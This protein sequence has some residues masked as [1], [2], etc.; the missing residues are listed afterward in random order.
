L[1]ALKQA[2]VKAL[3]HIVSCLLLLGQGIYRYW[4]HLVA[5]LNAA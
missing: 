3:K 1:Q 4:L 5:P 2:S